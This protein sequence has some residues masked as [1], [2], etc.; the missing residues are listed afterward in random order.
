MPQQGETYG[1]LSV[2]SRAVLARVEDERTRSRAVQFGVALPRDWFVSKE[3]EANL[4]SQADQTTNREASNE[5]SA[6]VQQ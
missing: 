1:E 3:E 5:R 2:D 4:V 6:G